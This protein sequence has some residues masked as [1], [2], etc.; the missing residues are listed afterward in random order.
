MA[1]RN[2]NRLQKRLPKGIHY[3]EALIM[4]NTGYKIIEEQLCF[5]FA[6]K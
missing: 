1:E 4:E 6:K 5:E 3:L 2:L